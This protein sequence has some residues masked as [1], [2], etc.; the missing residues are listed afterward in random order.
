LYCDKGRSIKDVR[1]RSQKKWPFPHCPHWLT[2]TPLCP[3]GHTINLEFFLHQNVRTSVSQK[4]LLSV[5]D[6]SPPPLTADVLYGHWI[7]TNGYSVLL[8]RRQASALGRLPPLTP[9]TKPLIMC[10]PPDI[11][12]I[13]KH[14]LMKS[15]SLFLPKCSRSSVESR[16]WSSAWKNFQTLAA[17]FLA[18]DPIALLAHHP[19][20][21]NV[22]E[23]TE[24]I[25]LSAE[26][27][28]RICQQWLEWDSNLCMQQQRH[29]RC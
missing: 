23:N 8:R 12:A 15:Y 27:Y 17:S 5:L 25:T 7:A 2:S 29:K 24:Y 4:T 16:L 3:C 14:A 13:R 21:A 11:F 18:S 28:L 1:R 20:D 19:T 6:K 22:G 26:I 9:I 10:N